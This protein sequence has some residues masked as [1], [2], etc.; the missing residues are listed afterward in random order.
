MSNNANSP[1]KKGFRIWIPL[2][3][4]FCDTD[5]MGHINNVAYIAYMETARVYYM[6]GLQ[7]L[8]QKT[9]KNAP[10]FSVILAEIRCRYKSQGFFNEEFEI[11]IRIGEFRRKSFTFEYLMIEKNSERA[12][13]E[14]DSIQVMFDYS[15]GKSM[16]IPKEF[17][18]LACELEGREIPI[19]SSFS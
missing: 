2:Q 11:G 13:I 10:V 4:R 18:E 1:D 17:I 5:M 9:G 7:E 6:K 16:P 12:V 19:R 14:G 8:A 15:A 3:V